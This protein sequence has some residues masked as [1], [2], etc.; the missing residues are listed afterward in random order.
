[1]TRVSTDALGRHGRH[2][3]RTLEVGAAARHDTMGRVTGRRGAGDDE[4]AEFVRAAWPRL[5]RTAYLMCGDRHEAED[6]VQSA[7]AKVVQHWARIER[8]DAPEAYA[9]RVLVNLVNSRW[10]RM[11]RYAELT[12]GDTGPGPVADPAAAVVLSDAVWR[13]LS[14]LP[15]RTRSILVLRYVE[16]LS[17]VDTASA[18]GCSVGA[19]KSQASRGLARLRERLDRHDLTLDT[20]PA[21]GGG[22]HE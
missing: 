2:A 16:D 8:R 19:V 12:A 3:T 1:M 10:R 18:L 7:L 22:T 13:G 4:A 11:K 5:H 15:P 17:E 20:T 14:T 21:P 6:L 9:R